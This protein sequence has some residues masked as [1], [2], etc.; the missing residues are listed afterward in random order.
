LAALLA[1]FT[2]VLL[3]LA[4]LLLPAALL[5]LT[6][7]RLLA[8]LL[9][10]SRRSLATLLLP[11]LLIAALI[12]LHIL[13][14]IIHL[15]YLI[16]ESQQSARNYEVAHYK[17]DHYPQD[18]SRFTDCKGLG[19]LAIQRSNFSIGHCASRSS[20]PSNET[21]ASSGLSRELHENRRPT[22]VSGPLILA[23]LLP[24]AGINN[25]SK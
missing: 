24:S 5:L 25:H 22:E 9:L 20:T 16:V 10:L 14:R 13:V 18:L 19:Q 12:V 8:A 3:L 4:G 1:A 17:H 2:G 15:K 23:A 11:L 6:R 21:L 7:L